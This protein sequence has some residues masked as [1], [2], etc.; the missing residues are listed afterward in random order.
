META[1]GG[2][3]LVPETGCL[4][5]PSLFIVD[6][7]ARTSASRHPPLTCTGGYRV[8]FPAC[9]S[10]RAAVPLKFE[11]RQRQSP[12]GRAFS[13]LHFP[14]PMPKQLT[15]SERCA[16]LHEAAEQLQIIAETVALEATR[17]AAA[18]KRFSERRGQKTERRAR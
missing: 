8:G 10:G 13:S 7:P 17:M 9:D 6:A 4:P 15:F 12:A 5:L 3:K 11:S 14:T 16:L 2:R 1:E 18:E